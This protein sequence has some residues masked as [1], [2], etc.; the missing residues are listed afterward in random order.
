MTTEQEARGL[1]ENDFFRQAT[2]RIFSSLVVEVAMKRCLD[3]LSQH[4]PAA[5]MFFVLYDPDLNIGRILA[6]NLPPHLRIPEEDFSIP[7]EFWH[8]FEARW[9]EAPGVMI[10]NDL[11]EADPPLR[12][13]MSML[14]PTEI[15]H[16]YLNLELEK[17]RLGGLGLLAEG[18]R[19]YTEYHAHLLSLLHEPFAMA[20]SNI[21]QHQE[22]QRFRDM[23]ADDN[24]YLRREMLNIS[25]DTVIGAN[26]GL[27]DTM[28]MVGRVAPLDSPVLLIGETGVGKEVIANTIHFSS[29]RRTGPYIKVNCGAIPENLIDSELFGHE[30]GAFTGAIARK[31]GRFERADTGTIFLD[32]IGDLPPAAQVRLLRVLQHHEVERVGGTESI[33]VNVR[34]IS[35]THHNLEAMVRSGQFR[36]D[37]WFRLNVFPILIP[38]LRHR[39]QDIPVLVIHFVERKSR[40]LK[41]RNLPSPAPGVLDRLQAYDWPGNVR[42]LENLVERELI[43]AQIQDR[44]GL[45]RFDTLSSVPATGRHPVAGD[46]DDPI[47]PLDAV[48]AAHIEKALECSGGRV[49]GENGAARK[50]GLHPS[51][52]RGR[53]RKMGIPHGRKRR[54]GLP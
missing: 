34:L 23:L 6:S 42:E 15:S 39:K 45:L 31:R 49:E 29:Q 13:F 7:R 3:Y 11:D 43:L 50:L 10:I 48:I 53:M 18:R 28:E 41:L 37:L 9:T 19:R 52:L 46:G 32:E 40:E 38:P 51:T 33:P 35:A 5:G 2:L 30:K 24:R 14:W 4:I 22:I 27:K 20:I 1:D 36:E 26:F 47:R 12:Q 21:L 17:Q 16:L 44:G 54:T 8:W 25:G